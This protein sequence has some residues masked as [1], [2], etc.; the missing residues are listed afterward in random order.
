MIPHLMNK[1]Q[2]STKGKNLGGSKVNLQSTDAESSRPAGERA[3]NYGLDILY[4]PPDHSK[5]VVDIVFIHGLTG[6]SNKTWLDKNGLYWPI[7]LLSKDISDTRILAFGYNAD[8]VNFWNPASQ[9]RISNHALDLLGDLSR[10][11]LGTDS[12]NRKIIFVAHSLGGLVT[13]DAIFIASGSAEIHIR[14]VGTCTTAIAFLGTPHFGSDLAGWAE[15]GG[16]I[17]KIM[18][19]AN[20]DIVSVLKPRSEMLAKVQ[21]GFYNVL[22]LREKENTQIAITCFYEELAVPLAGED[23]TKYPNSDDNGYGRVL[24]EIKRW[25]RPLCLAT[26]A[27][28]V[29][30]EPPLSKEDIECLQCLYTS[31]YVSHRKRNPDRVPGTCEWI[32]YH[33]KYQ[34]WGR[35]QKSSLLWVSA[36]PGC[37][38]SVLASYLVDKLNG[39][40]SQA[41]LPGTVCFFFFKDDNDSQKSATL[42]LCALLHQLFAVKNS[43]IKY[44]QPEFRNKKQKF[45]EEFVTLWNIFIT[46]AADKGCG[47]VICIIDGLDECEKL[48]QV[49]FIQSLVDFYSKIGK[50]V[51]T[52]PFLKILV[53]SR[54]YPSIEDKFH[55]LSMIRLRAEDETSSTSEDIERVVRAKVESFGE[56]RGISLEVQTAL[57][58]RL[59]KNADR[60][61]LWV[62]LVLTDLEGSPQASKTAL[63]DL[64]D[65]IPETLDAVYEKILNQSY[66]KRELVI[67]LLHIVVAAF[68]PL[69]LEEMNVAFV[70]KSMD[71]SHRDL[72][73]EPSIDK[74]VKSLC[75]LFVRVTDSKVYLIHQTAKEFLINSSMSINPS[76]WKHSLCLVESNYVLAQICIS[77]LLFTVFES[78]PL[79]IDSEANPREIQ[80]TVDLYTKKHSFLDYAAKHWAGHFREAKIKEET[81]FLKSVVDICNTRS[82]RFLT[83]FP[84]YWITVNPNSLCHPDFTDLIVG[85][86]FGLELVVGLLLENGANVNTAGEEEEEEEDIFSVRKITRRMTALHSAAEKGYE[87]VVRLLLENGADA[88]AEGKNI[89]FGTIGIRAALHLAAE[90]GH[91][92]V[93]QLLLENGADINAE[94]KKEEWRGGFG[95]ETTTGTRTA[96]HLAA[97]KGHEAVVRLLLENGADVNAEEKNIEFGTTGT[98]TALHLAAKKGHKAVVRLLLENGADVNTEEKEEDVF[99]SKTTRRTALQPAAKK[100]HEA[101]VRLLLENG[102]DVN[103]KE[104]EEKKE[105]GRGSGGF[106]TKTT[107]RIRTALQLAV[108][109]GH[110]AVVRLLLKNGADVNGEEEEVE[111]KDEFKRTTVRRRTALHL[112]T[113]SGYEAVVRLL[114]ENGADVNAEVEVKD[115]FE[116]TTVRRGTALHLA[117]E[118]EYEAV[119]RLLLE[120][121]ADVNAE[122]EVKVEDGFGRTTVRR[123]TALHLAT[124][125][126]HEAVVRLLLE[127]SADVNTEEK[128]EDV[129]RSKTTRRTALRP[130]A[131]KG[132]E[133]VVRLLLENSADVNAKE[134]EE[135]KEEGRGSGGFRTKTTTRIRTAL[136]LAVENG[137]EAVVR[138]LLKNGADVNG[139]EEEVEVKDEFKRTTVRR[140]TALHLATKSG[141]E[142]VVR[143]LLENGADVNA[144]VEVKDGFERTTVRRGTAL[145]LATENGYEAVV[146]LLLRNGADVNVEGGG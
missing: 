37:G 44:A 130:A 69:S 112:A 129:F 125:N 31:D 75:G 145:H 134:E 128:E 136:Q 84:V 107:T 50:Q 35:E 12:E 49:L 144:E 55:D 86:Y 18:K 48:T 133:A 40:K 95:G 138:L 114:L 103:A 121:G 132:H 39:H 34:S 111:V 5:A 15:F 139:E 98:R 123:G 7:E 61:F 74:T 8:M 68:R 33:E 62:S 110:E 100:G 59:I 120:N 80:E 127:N 73:L 78:H 63:D 89:E 140:R 25:V 22:R 45:A 131:K 142:A 66:F 108:E 81:G 11:R 51:T 109:N 24:G 137:H 58:E 90:K 115:G 83:W 4:E 60:T 113:K 21:D 105:E 57:A 93:V 72:D 79:V 96:L 28:D 1:I 88:N 106:R 38:K 76:S 116:R 30:V 82:E 47:N 23:M 124:E 52:G 54:P 2:K 56:K 141:Y 92:A 77:Y 126:G 42:A 41:T 104:E 9:N 6:S 143:L 135:K 16:R 3:T 67:K 118:N 53:T 70:I 85:S 87:A 13:E 29:K 17:A 36:D 71:K 43:L 14:Q 117:T 99:R 27:S 101:V 122:G 91:E 26:N 119:V 32:L 94:K 65:T 102:A 20:T 97:E 46:A 64:I 10:L 146:Q 19:H